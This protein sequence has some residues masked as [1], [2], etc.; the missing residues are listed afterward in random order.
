MINNEELPIGFTME[1]AQHS[2]A[3]VRFSGMTKNEQ[4]EIISQARDASSR[5]E[6]RHLVESIK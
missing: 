4:Q 6:M 2:D 1:L 5:E 3:L